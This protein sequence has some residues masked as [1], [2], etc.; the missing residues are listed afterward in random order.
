[1]TKHAHTK[2][3]ILV[4]NLVRLNERILETSGGLSAPPIF[5]RAMLS[6]RSPF[7][8]RNEPNSTVLQSNVYCPISSRIARLHGNGSYQFSCLRRHEN[9]YTFVVV[10][11][12]RPPSSFSAPSRHKKKL[13][14]AVVAIRFNNNKSLRQSFSRGLPLLLLHDEGDTFVSGAASSILNKYSNYVADA[15]GSRKIDKFRN[16]V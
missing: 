3:R 10:V 8:G 7:F 14:P 9:F 11:V 15:A 12:Q 16:G 2:L 1:M 4:V 5:E 13:T 6:S